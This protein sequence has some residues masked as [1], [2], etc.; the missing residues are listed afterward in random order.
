MKTTDF[1]KVL[2]SFL[3]VELPSVRNV[4][5]NTV[6]SYRDTFKQLLRFM[7]EQKGVRPEHLQ[8]SALTKDVIVSFLV[9]L[10]LNKLTI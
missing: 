3:T 9:Q 1:A 5:P 6:L 7:D 4:S 10:D 8:I 2:T